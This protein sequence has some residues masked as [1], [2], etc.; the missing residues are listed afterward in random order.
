MEQ[1]KLLVES[2]GSK[3]KKT[4][5]R[6]KDANRVV[7]D[8]TL[9][10]SFTVAAGKSLF[11]VAATAKRLDVPPYDETT[12]VPAKC[13]DIKTL[14]TPEGWAIATQNAHTLLANA[15]VLPSWVQATWAALSNWTEPDQK[16]RR[17]REKLLAYV[18][19][20]FKFLRVDRASL[21]KPLSQHV[22]A[23]PD[24]IGDQF[25]TQFTEL[26]GKD[27]VRTKVR[28]LVSCTRLSPLLDVMEILSFSLIQIL[29]T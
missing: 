21:N 6:T 20:L 9:H 29:K 17:R 1:R 14:L 27:R 15:H 22:T 13:Y 8:D 25:L 26:Q 18:I 19:Y 5:V 24:A 11:T 7:A 12:D 4:E 3:K 16:R 2:F 10:K 28:S 23:I